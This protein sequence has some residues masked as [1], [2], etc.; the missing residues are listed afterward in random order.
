MVV[1]GSEL[2]VDL[3]SGIWLVGLFF[4]KQLPLKQL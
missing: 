1:C 3:M 2:V 4:R